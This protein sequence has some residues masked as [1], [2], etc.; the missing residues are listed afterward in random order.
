MEQAARRG[1]YRTLQ[2]VVLFAS[3]AGCATPS[4]LPPGIVLP[5]RL[6]D[7]IPAAHAAILKYAADH[8]DALPETPAGERIIS[9]AIAQRTSSSDELDAAGTPTTLVESIDGI[10]YL[11]TVEQETFVM[12]L[13]GRRT[14][15]TQGSATPICAWFSYRGCYSHDGEV[16]PRHTTYLENTE[17][18]LD[19]IRSTAHPTGWNS[20]AWAIK[21][22]YDAVAA[23][24]GTASADGMVAHFVEAAVDTGRARVPA[25]MTPRQAAFGGT[26]DEATATPPA[27]N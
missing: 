6:Q 23:A 16:M 1:T 3:V 19:A 10:A 2:Q 15:M 18:F 17:L 8:D 13:C 12:I 26:P 4:A 20:S 7:E 11:C 9:S 21:R 24:H 25:G 22:C 27:S 5:S 14:Q